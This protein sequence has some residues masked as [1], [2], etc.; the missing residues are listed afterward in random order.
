[1]RIAIHIDSIHSNFG[2]RWIARLEELNINVLK[3]NCF[4]NNILGD[5]S[6][7]DGLMWHWYQFDPKAMLFAKQLML[8]LAQSGKS[9]FPDPNTSWHFD[10]KVGQKYL[11]EAVDAPIVPSHVFYDIKTAKAWL[12]RSSFPLVFKLRGGAASQN[13]RLV[14]DKNQAL[15]LVNQAFG[16]GFSPNDGWGL[17]MDRLW[18]LKRDRNFHALYMLLRGLGRLIVPTDLERIMGR[19]KGYLYFQDFLPN[20]SYDTRVIVIGD[21]AFGI[22]RYNRA[23]DFRAS[24][25]GLIEYDKSKIDIRCVQIAFDVNRRLRAQCLAYDFVFDLNENPRIVEISYAFVERGYDPCPGFWDSDLN[26]HEGKFNPQEFMV[27]D[28]IKSILK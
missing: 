12:E 23:G 8:S 14:R 17:V 26:W 22:V 24:G 15:K 9:V 10:D 1:M 20:N 4:S 18:Q 7:C 27:D 16:R 5:I 2:D 13:V 25:S 28:F 3:V 21:R 6:E 19:E 11:L